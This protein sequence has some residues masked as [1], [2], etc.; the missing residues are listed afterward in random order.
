MNNNVNNIS[1][2]YS[3]FG[4][5]SQNTLEK[6]KTLVDSLLEGQM[7]S[8]KFDLDM[9]TD[10]WFNIIWS[11]ILSNGEDK[12]IS[13]I[14]DI[15]KIDLANIT[16]RDSV[17]IKALCNAIANLNAANK[18]AANKTE[19]TK[20]LRNAF[21]AMPLN[22]RT[23]ESINILTEILDCLNSKDVKITLAQSAES[24]NA[25][26]IAKDFGITLTKKPQT[27]FDN[28]I[29]QV[30]P[31]LVQKAAAEW[32]AYFQKPTELN[33]AILNSVKEDYLQNCLP[34]DLQDEQDCFNEFAKFL[35]NDPYDRATNLTK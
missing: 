34:I 27:M 19:G 16:F 13:V 6:E 22:T 9:A 20:H 10:I 23:A 30:G 35:N 29:Y 3:S 15:V 32:N 11:N 24:Y 8:N 14:G 26:Q 28:N 12:R 17:G 25:K 18:N 4:N 21:L 2:P 33:N 7:D 31:E 1:V 5:V